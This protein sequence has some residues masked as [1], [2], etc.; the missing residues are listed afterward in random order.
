MA[1]DAAARGVGELGTELLYDNGLQ[2]YIIPNA[3]KSGA[4]ASAYALG[5]A[6]GDEFGRAV[7]EDGYAPDWNR[8]ANGG[9]SAFAFG[10]ANDLLHSAA[11]SSRNKA[12]I[13]EDIDDL[14]QTYDAAKR[15]LDDPNL[16]AEQ[17]A[18]M[19]QRVIDSAQWA[20]SRL[21]DLNLVGAQREVNAAHNALD[22]IIMEM[23]GYTAN[24]TGLMEISPFNATVT[25]PASQQQYADALLQ[26]Y[27]K[28]RQ[29]GSDNLARSLPG[30]S[31]TPITEWTDGVDSGRIQQDDGIKVIEGVKG[32]KA[33]LVQETEWC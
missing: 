24:N 25:L 22:D 18:M 12:H 21:D 14:R 8:I 20:G 9:A 16:S 32:P 1:S 15:L 5:E 4:S 23:R 31:E 17:R 33:A 29:D 19:A 27:N 6:G 30:H 10:F 2:N 26:A 11:V 28:L 13:Q 3:L 7:T